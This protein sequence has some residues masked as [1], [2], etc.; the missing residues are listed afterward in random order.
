MNVGR[1]INAAELCPTAEEVRE[2]LTGQGDPQRLAR[3]EEHV[4]LCDA[5]GASVAALSDSEEASDAV[6]QALSALPAA[7]EDEPEFQ[8]L[9]STLLTMSSP[10][11]HGD[12]VRRLAD[13]PVGELPQTLGNYELLACVGRGAWGAIYRA[14][15][16][17]LDQ[18]VAVKVLDSTRLHLAPAMDHFLQEMKA[19]GQLKHPN[20]VR[21]TD[22]GEDR[23]F[24]FLV[25]E[26]LPGVDAARLRRIEPNLAV[27]D[28]CEIVRQAAVALDFAH[29]QSWIHRD[30]KPSNLMITVAGQVKLLDLGIAGRRDVDSSAS[31][32]QSPL[33]TAEYMAPEQWKSFATVD[34]R[35]DVYSLGCTL[36]KLL[37]GHAPTAEARSPAI[38]GKGIDAAPARASVSSCRGDVRR[39][40]DRIVQKMLAPN[41]DDR[42]QSAADVAG[43]L[44]PWARRADLRALVLRVSAGDEAMFTPPLAEEQLFEPTSPPR[45]GRRALLGG[46]ACLA[47]AGVLAPW[48]QSWRRP[49]LRRSQWRP[50]S[51]DPQGFLLIE[52]PRDAANFELKKAG[53]LRIHSDRAALIGLGRAVVA[54]FA[55]HVAIAQDA[56]RGAAGLFFRWRRIREFPP[57]VEFQSI[58]AAHDSER[59]ALGAKRLVWRHWTARRESSELT[60]TCETLAETAVEVPHGPGP[61][62]LHIALGGASVPEVRFA[63]ADLPANVWTLSTEG[64]RLANLEPSRLAY[65]FLG[66]LGLI[67]V[68]GAAEFHTPE[69]SYL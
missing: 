4:A 23:G 49:R 33:G 52:G 38:A 65:E 12:E 11:G 15:H 17:K 60:L 31:A 61:Q 53:Q 57:A 22:A 19:A 66:G 51:P 16:Q 41:R 56:D 62:M 64:R 26:Y 59:G 47:G 24:H 1:K 14:R 34:A 20:I 27:A 48:L 35:A 3:I 6:L 67:N 42:Y 5:C 58:E 13:P 54:P 68:D 39:G 55:L 18:I 46:L 50:L 8:Q 29:R 10:A 30:V 36:I 7:A 44:K 9:Q 2:A 37:T 25:M 45:V 43:A 69:L 40:L 21:A 28:C 32:E 63:G